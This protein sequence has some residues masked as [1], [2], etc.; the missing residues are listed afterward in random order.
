MNLVTAKDGWPRLRLH[1]FARD[2]GCVA[3]QP[4]IFGSDIATDQCRDAQGFLMAWNDFFKLEFEHVK[5]AIGGLR[6]S[7]DEAHGVAACPWHHRLGRW[8]VDTKERRA[9]T[10]AY[11]A[12]L[13]PEVWNAV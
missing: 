3:V 11:L 4:A 13:Y 9:V 7:D 1:V 8:R 2:R 5:E 6:A 10:R 12:S